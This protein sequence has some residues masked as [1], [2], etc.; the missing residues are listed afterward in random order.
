M[1]VFVSRLWSVQNL[2]KAYSY[3]MQDRDVSLHNRLIFPKSPFV[4]SLCL[5]TLCT[6]GTLVRESGNWCDGKCERTIG[7]QPQYIYLPSPLLPSFVGM[8]SRFQGP[9]GS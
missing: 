3:D 8:D 5:K 7:F 6:C 4:T 2:P 1:P 9:E